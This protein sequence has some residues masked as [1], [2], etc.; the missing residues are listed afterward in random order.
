[1]QV[2]EEG[3]VGLGG[4]QNKGGGRERDVGGSAR[5]RLRCHPCI[6]RRCLGAE[7]KQ[8][9][10]HPGSKLSVCIGVTSCVF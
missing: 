8:T 4:G 5:L 3:V 2:A 7:T 9:G 10:I 6:C 1:M